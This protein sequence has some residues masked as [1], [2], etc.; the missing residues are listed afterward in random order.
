M[1]LVEN[2]IR[3]IVKRILTE[4]YG[5]NDEVY[6]GANEI[7][8]IMKQD[9]DSKTD[10]GDCSSAFGSDDVSYIR[11]KFPYDIANETIT[12]SYYSY[13][14]PNDETYKEYRKKY[15]RQLMDA[16]SAY[17]DGKPSMHI[18]Y[19]YSHESGYDES[20]YD[21]VQHE[22]EHLFQEIK[23]GGSFN[24]STLKK[25]V[26]KGLRQK[27]R[28]IFMASFIL[29]CARDYEQD[30]CANGLYSWLMNGEGDE[31]WAINNSGL[32]RNRRICLKY[33]N[34][35]TSKSTDESISNKI[36]NY[37]G[38]SLAKVI[39]KGYDACGKMKY[40]ANKV[41]FKYGQDTGNR[42]N[43]IK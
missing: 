7:L 27:D 12:V 25:R 40:K 34:D 3:G 29:Y 35:L 26:N 33:L 20:I 17:N 18:V 4:E 21:R 39:K 2:K 9:I 6:K 38:I 1:D 32:V 31:E 36:G 41:I 43:F 24:P 23:K 37:L 30:A 22:L 42:L 14:F 13:I 8:S 11:G 19:N 16:T 5:I 10:D 15:P 28:D